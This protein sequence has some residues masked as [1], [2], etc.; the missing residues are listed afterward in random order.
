MLAIQKYIVE[1][2]LD[3]AVTVFNLK[4]R[5]YDSKVLLKYDIC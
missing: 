5:E 2:G 4:T 1:N 3:K